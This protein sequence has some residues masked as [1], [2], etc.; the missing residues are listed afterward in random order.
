MAAQRLVLWFRNDL[1]VHD[2]YIIAEAAKK[3]SSNRKLEVVPVYCF[4]PRFLATT[5]QYGPK[6]CGVIRAKFLQESVVDLKKNLKSIGSD[7]LVY[8]GTPETI[9]PTLMLKGAETTVLAQEEVTD[10]ELRVDRSVRRA[11]KPLGGDLKLIWGATLFHKDDLPFKPELVDMPD[12]FTPFKDACEKKS[13]GVRRCVH[14]PS[15]LPSLP[16]D[17]LDKAKDEVPMLTA[18]GYSKEEAAQVAKPDPR[19]VLPFRGGE[20]AAL[21]RVKDYLWDKDR[22]GIYFETRNGMIG[23]DYSS[24]F[25]AWLAHG[26]LSPRLIH[27]EVKRYERERVSN[28]ST[29]WLIFELIWRDFFRFFCLKHGNDVFQVG[30][31]VGRQWQWEGEGEAFERWKDG[32]TGQPLVDSNMRELKLTG[33]MSNRGRQNVASFLTQNLNVD[34]RLGAAYFEETLIDH[35]VTANWGNWM[36]AAGLSGGR[37]NKFNILKQSSDYDDN[38]DY[39]RLWCPELAQ[40]P[41]PKVHS[42]WQLSQDEQKKF[43]VELVP[44]PQVRGGGAGMYPKPV[45]ENSP[46]PKGGGY[47]GDK[48]GQW[49]GGPPKKRWD[50]VGDKWAADKE[51]G[52]G[53]G[54]GG[55]GK[56]RN[57]NSNSKRQD[58]MNA[59]MGLHQN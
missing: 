39:C 21:A 12:V 31:T 44:Y 29:Y 20:T 40:V 47:G 28:K 2:N 10:E 32:T 46:G 53:G 55:G 51:G 35:D 22:L 59:H 33:F 36:F 26:C 42:P 7:L 38:G 25:S 27:E 54:G 15:F 3:I 23:A 56:R 4:D 24:K 16:A 34:W 57:N 30:G 19:S 14:S 1:R 45:K 6:K 37:V 49:R 13:K 50:R 43:G 17:V 9:I 5:S 18:L 58:M 41:A 52:R 48:Q 11:I 8:H